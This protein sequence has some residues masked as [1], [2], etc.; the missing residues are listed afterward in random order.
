[1]GGNDAKKLDRF[2]ASVF[3]LVLF[4]L[5]NENDVSSSERSYKFFTNH[6]TLAFQDVDLVFP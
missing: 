6:K 3:K 5:R 4:V 2:F 1:M